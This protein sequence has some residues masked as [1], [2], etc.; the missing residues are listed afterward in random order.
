MSELRGLVDDLHIQA[1]HAQ[2]DDDIPDQYASMQEE[3]AEQ[4]EQLVDRN[5][6]QNRED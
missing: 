4:L 5:H 6:E 1:Y 3:L 2:I